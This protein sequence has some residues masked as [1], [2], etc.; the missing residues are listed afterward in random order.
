MRLE[1]SVDSADVM[2]VYAPSPRGLLLAGS[3]WR[4]KDGDW[5]ALTVTDVPTVARA[6]P[7]AAAPFAAAAAIRGPRLL[8]RLD[9]VMAPVAVTRAAGPARDHTIRAG[10]GAW[11]LTSDAIGSRGGLTR[12]GRGDVRRFTWS[13]VGDGDAAAVLLAPVEPAAA[14]MDLPRAVLEGVRYWCLPSGGE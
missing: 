4:R 3:V 10:R 5:D 12:Y 11:R 9:A 13:L 1:L 7:R 2:T 14:L 8:C 6:F